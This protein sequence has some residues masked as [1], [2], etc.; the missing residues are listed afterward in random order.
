[1]DSFRDKRALVTGAASGIGRA[2]A[3]ALAR[4]GA[5]LCLLD[6][7]EAGL[8]QTAKAVAGLQADVVTRTC[9]LADPQQISASLRSLLALRGDL[10]I[11]VNC[12]GVIHHARLHQ[13]TDDA[14][15]RVMSVNLLAP[16]QLVR[17]SLPTL[18]A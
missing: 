13:T 11:L 5:S 8:A 6:I 12:A 2:I 1:M 10:N 16:I 18:L 4:E 9:D 3:L 15:N 17:E 14:W 7:D